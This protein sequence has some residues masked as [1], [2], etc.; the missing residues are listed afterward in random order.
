M[1]CICYDVVAYHILCDYFLHFISGVFNTQNTPL[2]MAL[3]FAVT[4]EQQS[5]PARREPMCRLS[6]SDALGSILA[7][8]ARGGQSKE[9][10]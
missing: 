4:H 1:Y 2:V 7:A 9:R 3:G 10:I 8:A 6:T 5:I